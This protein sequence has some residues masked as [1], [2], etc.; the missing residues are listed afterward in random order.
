MK[1]ISIL[2]NKLY[3]VNEYKIFYLK[4]VISKFLIKNSN[5]FEI[6]I[7]IKIVIVT[8]MK[9]RRRYLIIIIILILT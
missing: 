2:I 4:N 3:I 5:F 6:T 7:I 1:I 9:H 8:K